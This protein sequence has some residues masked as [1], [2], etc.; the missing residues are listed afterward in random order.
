MES[1]VGSV[2]VQGTDC[3]RCPPSSETRTN[4]SAWRVKYS[5][6]K[7][8]AVGTPMLIGLGHRKGV[9]KDTFASFLKVHLLTLGIKASTTSFADQLKWCAHRIWAWAGLQ[10][11]NYYNTPEG[12]CYKD[13]VL[14]AIGKSPRE[15]WIEFGNAVRAIHK[16]T[17]VNLALNPLGLAKDYDNSQVRIVTDVRFPNE[18]EIIRNSGG[19]LIR[20][21]RDCS[22]LVVDGADE[23]LKGY[24]GWDVAIKNNGT[25]EE[26]QASA[27]YMA[28]FIKREITCDR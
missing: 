20:V 27:A 19:M 6:G 16:D 18:A 7:R 1:C 3:G 28:S 11:P 14:T 22:P 2:C 12:Y 10:P 13:I 4:S 23:V 17:W 9:G 24:R 8:V 5:G 21:D 25:K 15:L 26:L